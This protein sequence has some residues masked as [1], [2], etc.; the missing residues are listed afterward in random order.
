MPFI[1]R[2]INRWKSLPSHKKN[3]EASYVAFGTGLTTTFL[4]IPLV[5]HYLD[6]EELGI[7]ALIYQVMLYLSLINGG[8]SRSLG[9]MM[10]PS[11]DEKND[12]EVSKWWTLGISIQLMQGLILVA[13]GLALTSLFLDFYDLDGRYRLEASALFKAAVYTFGLRMVFEMYPGVLIAQDRFHW[14]PINQAITAILK[15]FALAA[16]LYNGKGLISYAYAEILVVLFS[17]IYYIYIVRKGGTRLAFNF[18]CFDKSRVVR[19]L[20]FSSSQAFLNIGATFVKALPVMVIGKVL[21]VDKVAIFTFTNRLPSMFTSLSLRNYHSRFP[22]LQKLYIR[23]E[24][25][26]GESIFIDTMKLSMLIAGVGSA[27]ILCCNRSVI[28]LISDSEFYGGTWLTFFLLVNVFVKVLGDPSVG[29]FIILG[30]M[31]SMVYV[32]FA[33]AVLTLV[34]ILWLTNSFGMIGAVVAAILGNL[35]T[36][37]LY[38][39]TVGTKS[40]GFNR[41]KIV[42]PLLKYFLLCS[43]CVALFAMGITFVNVDGATWFPNVAEI[44]LFV[45]VVIFASLKWKRSRLSQAGNK[46]NNASS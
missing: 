13:I 17:A 6:R 41:S 45:C 23:G 18:S 31:K 34:L 32:V 7:W 14:V 2:F 37:V 9:R 10:A 44:L 27:L 20:T 40:L 8:V 29:L 35:C 4:T 33:E 22:Q 38:G 16:F 26:K 43:G 28:Y 12:E 24:F 42:Y 1:S 46:V 25:S 21:G 11:I 36:R 19:L 30:N 5:V 15:L 39:Y 3:S